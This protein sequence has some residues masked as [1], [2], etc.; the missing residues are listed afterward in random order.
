MFMVRNVLVSVPIVSYGQGSG[1]EWIMQGEHHGPIVRVIEVMRERL[2]EQISL[3]DMADIACLSPYYF[4]RL[5]HHTIG[6][7]P[8]E[9]LAALR[10]DAAKRLMLTTDA[11]VTDICF[12]VGYN[13]LGSF[14]SR[15]TTQ[16]GISPRHLRIQTQQANRGGLVQL[17]RNLPHRLSQTII[18][19]TLEAPGFAGGIIFVG[20]F[21]RAIPQGKPL[22]CTRLTASG[23]FQLGPVAAGTYYLFAA[24]FV[25][26]HNPN[27]PLLSSTVSFVGKVGPI[28]IQAGEERMDVV[29]C[30]R[31]LRIT[32]PPILT[33]LFPS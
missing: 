22:N 19:G 32:D 5:F 6:L 17:V 24:A 31:S 18:S 14:T 29:M 10:I 20:L 4:N 16:V 9:F 11:S 7:P 13:A 12:A 26:S 15:F 27:T 1:D 28:V 33:A 23:S 8:G 2:A 30:M 21:P 25:R 3:H